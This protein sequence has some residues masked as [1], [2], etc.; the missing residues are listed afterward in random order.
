[1]QWAITNPENFSTHIHDKVYRNAHSP[2]FVAFSNLMD[3]LDKASKAWNR[4]VREIVHD[5]QN[6]FEK[7][8]VHWHAIYSRPEL[9]KEEP[10][11]W[12]GEQEP[13]SLS[14]APGSKLRLDT[15]DNSPGLQV[16]DVVLWLFKRAMTGQDIGPDGARLLNRVFQ[17]GWQVDLSFEGVGCSLGEKLDEI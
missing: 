1:M 12:P 7:T 17:R 8:F 15:E 4:S 11:R 6:Q 2:N 3:G 10:V 9:A 13:I 16:V 14:K 5:R